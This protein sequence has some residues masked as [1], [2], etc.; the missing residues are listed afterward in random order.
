MTTPS[1]CETRRHDIYTKL[2]TKLS[3]KTF[4][5]TF[6]ILVSVLITTFSVQW[7]IINENSKSSYITEGDIKAI[8]NDT[9]WIKQALQDLKKY[10]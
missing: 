7:Q 3:T 6:G 8:M 2:D 4:V 1:Q 9:A 10:N 5:W